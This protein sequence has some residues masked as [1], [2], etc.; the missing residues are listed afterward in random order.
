MGKPPLT[1][2]GQN[3]SSGCPRGLAA[4]L[5]RCVTCPASPRRSHLG[6]LASAC[7]P[8]LWLLLSPLLS[9]PICPILL[10]SPTPGNQPSIRL[11]AVHRFRGP[12]PAWEPLFQKQHSPETQVKSR[13]SE[14]P[15]SSCLSWGTPAHPSPGATGRRGCVCTADQDKY[16]YGWRSFLRRVEGNKPVSCDSVSFTLNFSSLIWGP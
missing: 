5:A 16:R 9:C 14:H 3:Q 8:P 15:T 2:R 7:P 13:V 10:A 11:P 6:P 4:L 12:G 1:P